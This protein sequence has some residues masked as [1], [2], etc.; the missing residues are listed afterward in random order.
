LF[1]RFRSKMNKKNHFKYPHASARCCRTQSLPTSRGTW[2]WSS[3]GQ[4][5]SPLSLQ[6]ATKASRRSPLTRTES[7]VSP[8]SRRTSAVIALFCVKQTA[9]VTSV[10]GR[11]RQS[12]SDA[13]VNEHLAPIIAN[14]T[15]HRQILRRHWFHKRHEVGHAF[16]HGGLAVDGDSL[17]VVCLREQL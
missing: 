16:A 12:T 13:P 15:W 4:E 1:V 2:M 5:L 6:L 3:C 7:Q 14:D 9:S 10:N 8:P 11:Q 17:L